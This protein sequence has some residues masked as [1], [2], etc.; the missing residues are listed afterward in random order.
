MKI[1]N[2]KKRYEFLIRTLY[3]ASAC[4]LAALCFIYIIFMKTSSQSLKWTEGLP[5]SDYRQP[6]PT[7]L[8]T[9]VPSKTASA[10]AESTPKITGTQFVTKSA[11]PNATVTPAPKDWEHEAPKYAGIDLSKILFI[12]D[13]I[14]SGLEV[15]SIIPDL[16]VIANTGMSSY[17]LVEHQEYIKEL[18]PDKIFILLG[19]NDM[20]GSTENEKF[21]TNYG[22]FIK[23][24]QKALPE[25]G[26]IVQA[27]FPVTK[28]VDENNGNVTN[29][30][31]NAF[32]A[33]LLKMANELNV[34]YVDVR[35]IFQDQNGYMRADISPDGI[36]F[37]TESYY[38]WMEKLIPYMK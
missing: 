28:Y 22:N 16:K 33:R 6:S 25:T 5:L 3:V 29:V 20:S 38:T 13:S 12:G 1:N 14:T 9:S 11:D 34:I 30:I 8:P 31:I 26:I 36:H 7:A 4:T 35:S 37:Y 15:Y 19:L 2:S 27:M 23:E 18:K 17:N 10:T 24:L 21:F 32:N